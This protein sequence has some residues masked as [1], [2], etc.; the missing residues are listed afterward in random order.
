MSEFQAVPVVERA[1]SV[2]RRD[3]WRCC[4]C[5]TSDRN[6]L[7]F[8]ITAILS[9]F[10]MLFSAGMLA[11]ANLPCPEQNTMV[12]LITLTLGYWLKSPLD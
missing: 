11:F 8:S 5:G 10:I 1:D 7:R 9:G 4:L 6:C 2:R 12:G 3:L